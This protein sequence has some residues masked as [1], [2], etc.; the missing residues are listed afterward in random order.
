MCFKLANTNV[1]FTC[2]KEKF[3][4]LR[5][6]YQCNDPNAKQIDQ[7]IRQTCQL[8]S[9]TCEKCS[10]MENVACRDL[11]NNEGEWIQT[12]CLKCYNHK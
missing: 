5:V 7:I 10:S 12:L 2:I 8:A 3:G 11:T 9:K 4:D 6:Y 1:I